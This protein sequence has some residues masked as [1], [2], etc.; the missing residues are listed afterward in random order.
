MTS[1]SNASHTWE[2]FRSGG[3]DQVTLASGADLLNLKHLDQKLWVALS[4]PVK[5]L[6]LDEKT[7]GLIDAD[8]DG[9][10]RVPELLA[11]IDWAAAHLND[12][13]VLLRGHDSVPLAALD[14]GSPQGAGVLA[15]ARGIL[16]NLGKADATSISLAEA[17]DTAR[18]FGQS[19]FNGDG[20]ITVQSTD[21]AALQQLIGEIAATQGSVADRSGLSGIDQARVDGFFA[22]A[23]SYLAWSAQGRS[24]AV[25]SLGDKTAAAADAVAAL[26][27][28]V[29]DFFARC[30]LAA[31]DARALNAVNRQENEYLAVAAQDMKITSQEVAGFPLA[32]IEPDRALPLTTGV[33]PAWAGKVAA[34]RQAAF[35]GK[36]SVTEAE[37]L[38]L[39]DQVAA[40]TTWKAG[41]V[42]GAV[43]ALGEDRLKAILAG[44]GKDALSALIAEDLKF[45]GEVASIDA[46]ARLLRYARDL[47]T[48][49]HNFVN[50]GD[51]YS[52]DRLATFQA[53]TL[54]LDSRSCDLCVR[55]DDPG[56]HGAMA[57][58]AKFY[59]A[60][61]DLKRPGGESM[62]IAACFTQGDSDYLMVGRN[63]L[64]Y[65]RKGRDWDATI[66]KVIDNPIS[67]RQAFFAPYKKFI[68]GIEE[69]AAKRAAAA[70]AASDAKMSA[71]ANAAANVDKG[72][73]PEPK[74]LDVGT[75]AAIGVAASAAVAVLT[76][77]VGGILGLAAWQ[78]P[79]AV[80]GV[81]L[82]IS[83]PSMLV[84][85]LKLRQRT[86]GPVL[87]A[88]GWAIN[89]RVKVN[90]PF[91]TALTSRAV[92][93]AGSRR[94]L[95]DPYAE[96][97]TPWGRY[98]FLLVLVG[99]AV[100]IRWD[101]NRRGH[102]FWQKP[103][104]E[105]PAE[106]TPAAPD[107]PASP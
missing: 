15:S 54:F 50:F 89:G 28:K 8:K 26:R 98:L 95:T 19:K 58:L 80:I 103:V 85:M 62:K 77:I 7:L 47:R 11:A 52:P 6:E 51:F 32:R 75:V 12:A 66:I 72:P 42:G 9:R 82:A 44:G 43:A 104:V 4:C 70:E 2:F 60:Y 64:F 16:R 35:P 27:D 99:A 61:C 73:K 97:K 94:N 48:L 3:L 106:P 69:A 65:D 34:L 105:V 14:A 100:W 107:T 20:V 53:G 87:D 39:C 68:R 10:I 96:K 17:S 81:L 71:A 86:L 55:V 56:A 93:P 29:D 46:T 49:L 59:I 57:G 67:I 78:I 102:Y 13:S 23:S 1:S 83:G 5:G 40:Y 88:N 18:I 22:A 36:V 33:N 79:L 92:L 45:A 25:L 41:I 84:A 101:H 37:W 74:K 90:I 91:G 63:G 24:P 21:D 30:R 31:F 38:A 76:S